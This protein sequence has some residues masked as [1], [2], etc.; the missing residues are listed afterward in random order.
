MRGN[1]LHCIMY[2]KLHISLNERQK[3]VFWKSCDFMKVLVEGWE[4]EGGS[5][6]LEAGQF[7]N[8]LTTPSTASIG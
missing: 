1:Q 7:T 2:I 3:I 5:C 8:K 6:E 4:G